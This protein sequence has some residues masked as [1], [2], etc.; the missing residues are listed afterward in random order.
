[1]DRLLGVPARMHAHEWGSLLSCASIDSVY[2]IFAWNTTTTTTIQQEKVLWCKH[3]TVGM[4]RNNLVQ[5]LV[6]QPP[7]TSS[8][9]LLL[10]KDNYSY[11]VANAR[12][13][14]LLLVAGLY[15]LSYHCARCGLAS[16]GWLGFQSS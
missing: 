16:R 4:H 5:I 3:S 7:R 9:Y 13:C 8:R 6:R 12:L 1:M 14:P 15:V 2:D 10:Q 11:Y